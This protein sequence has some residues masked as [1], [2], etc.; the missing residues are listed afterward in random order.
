MAAGVKDSSYSVAGS[1]CFPL[2]KCSD[3]WHS[4]FFI[5]AR[6]MEAKR[7]LGKREWGVVFVLAFLSFLFMSLSL[8][9]IFDVIFLVS[10]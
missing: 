8:P 1:C 5:L 10:R 4:C 2:A 7:V 6:K 3:F 9:S